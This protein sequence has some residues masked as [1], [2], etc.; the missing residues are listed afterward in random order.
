MGVILAGMPGA[1]MFEHADS[2]L[3]SS[4]HAHVTG[5]KWWHV[6]GRQSADQPEVCFEEVLKPGDI[7]YYPPSW[8]HV[9]QCLDAPTITLTDTVIHEGNAEGIFGK[10]FGECTGNANMGFDFSAKLCD[11]LDVC[12]DWWTACWRALERKQAALLARARGEEGH[13][14]EG[15][16]CPTAQQLRW[17]Q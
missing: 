5:K 17:P 1:G 7:L 9:T 12:T 4:W 16:D 10:T 11:A 3:T 15:E 13:R 14:R 2:L 8:V 6:C